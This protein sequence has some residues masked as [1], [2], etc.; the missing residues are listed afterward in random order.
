MVAYVLRV[1]GGVPADDPAIRQAVQ[2]IKTHQRQSGYWYTRSPKINDELSTSRNGLRDHGGLHACGRC[3]DT[4]VVYECSDKRDELDGSRMSRTRT[5]TQDRRSFLRTAAIATSSFCLPT[6]R[7]REPSGKL[8]R[9]GGLRAVKLESIGVLPH[10]ETRSPVVRQ[11]GGPCVA[12]LRRESRASG[13]A[14]GEWAFEFGS[15][16]F[17]RPDFIGWSVC[18]WVDTWHSMPGKEFKQHSGFFSPQGELHSPYV[19]RLNELSDRLYEFAQ[20]VA[21]AR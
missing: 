13:L 16:A 20:R 10:R 4:A 17:A 7:G 11:A 21:G 18:G 8:D 14:P 1:A 9:Y 3:G 5:H 19:R 12:R 2:W 15:N 6:A